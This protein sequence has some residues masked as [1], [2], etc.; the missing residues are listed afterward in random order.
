[1]SFDV[2]TRRSGTFP[3]VEPIDFFTRTLP[4]VLKRNARLLAPFLKGREP[5]PLAIRVAGE[6]WTLR[7]HDGGVIIEAGASPGARI[8][9][10]DRP[11][12]TDLVHDQITPNGWLTRGVLRSSAPLSDLLDWWLVLRGGIDGTAPYVPGAISFRE[13]DGSPLGL[14]RS[15]TLDDPPESMRHFLYE[16]GFLHVRNVFNPAEMAAISNDM[17]RFAS[18]YSP[19]DARSYWGTTV[20]GAERLVRMQYFDTVS[21][22]AAEIAHDTRIQAITQ[23]TGDSHEPNY[24]AGL[25]EALVKPA[26]MTGQ[27]SDFPWHKDCSLGRHSHECCSLTLGISI[28]PANGDRGMLR[29][30]A[31]SHRALAWPVLNQPE[32]DLP[33]VDLEADTGDVTMHLSCTAH[34][35]QAPAACERRVLYLG[36]RLPEL[37]A[38]AAADARQRS[39][40]RTID[41][42]S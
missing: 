28:T 17:D 30:I 31:G 21:T 20:D 36:F 29:V 6:A 1:M 11:E 15:F 12:L 10:L 32:M 19:T 9:L 3:V 7:V 26:G 37:D 2:R 13:R 41:L 16:T 22:C 35:S 24:G 8:L 42:I 27:I 25:V 34:M 33:V 5:R 40:L 18:L 39:G 4:A 23:L 14:D 38:D